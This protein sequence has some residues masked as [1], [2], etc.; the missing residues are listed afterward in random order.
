[1][2]SPTYR[3]DPI[4]SVIIPTYRQTTLLRKC[5]SSVLEQEI[6]DIEVIVVDNGSSLDIPTVL[7]SYRGPRL[8][9]VRLKKN[10][11]FCAA[12]NVGIAEARGM[13][14]ATLNDDC[15]LSADWAGHIIDSFE[16]G[17]DIASVASLVLRAEHPSL[18]DSAGSHV[19][20]EGLAT[21]ILWNEPIHKAPQV[22]VEVFAPSSSCAAYRLDDLQHAGGFDNRFIAYMED[23]DVGFRLQLQGKKILF[24]PRCRAFH[25]GAATNKSRHRSTFLMERNRILN[26][27][28]N[29]PGSLISKNWNKIVR[30]SLRPVPLHIT[31]PKEAILAGKLAG[32]ARIPELLFERRTIQKGRRVSTAH[33]ERLMA[34]KE[35][36]ACK[37]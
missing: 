35:V 5:V 8:R 27:T 16:T 11:F 34:S 12:I 33:I 23:I 7:K 20:T 19:N 29:F 15:A 28:K 1:M 18:I 32:T 37:L 21:N 30:A 14:V 10:R 17:R 9:I 31:G 4:I 26:I 24:N 22:T 2:T 25:V 6:A 36:G 3:F 13:Y